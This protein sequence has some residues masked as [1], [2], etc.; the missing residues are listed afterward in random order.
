MEAFRDYVP[1]VELHH[2]NHDGS[3]YPWGLAGEDI[4][5]AA[6]IV[7]VA[8]AYDAMVTDRPY[9]KG[10]AHAAAVE[11]LKANAGS[12]FDPAAVNAFVSCAAPRLTASIADHESDVETHELRNLA[13]GLA[14]E[15]A[16]HRARGAAVPPATLS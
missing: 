2:E 8:D 11:I 9:R 5:V 15:E 6:R 7:H 16:R 14:R 1:V 10:L 3:G 4:P 12:Q 13:D